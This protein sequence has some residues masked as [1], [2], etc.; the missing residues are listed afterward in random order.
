MKAFITNPDIKL[1]EV[2]GHT[3]EQGNDAYNLDLSTPPRRHRHE[4]LR[5]H[6]IDADRL[7]SKGYGETAPV[8][9]GTR[10]RR[11]S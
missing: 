6:G 8:D 9:N 4:Y 3:D 2:Q 1:V 11:T 10:K 7:T 5:D